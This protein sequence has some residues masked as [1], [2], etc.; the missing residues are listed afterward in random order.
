[1]PFDYQTW[2]CSSRFTHWRLS[3]SFLSP[4]RPSLYDTY[5]KGTHKTNIHTTNHQQIPR[6]RH[7]CVCLCVREKKSVRQSKRKEEGESDLTSCRCSSSS[8]FSPSPHRHHHHRHGGWEEENWTKAN[9]CIH[10]F[11]SFSPCDPYSESRGAGAGNDDDASRAEQTDRHNRTGKSRNLLPLFR[12]LEDGK[13]VR[14][15]MSWTRVCVYNCEAMM[16]SFSLWNIFLFLVPISSSSHN[17]SVGI[18]LPFFPPNTFSF[19][20]IFSSSDE[21]LYHY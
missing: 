2:L 10:M 8:S 17:Q 16:I 13:S 20:Q 21:S 12:I 9:T 19:H 14:E 7:M 11:S 4:F 3:S 6:Q 5:A 1:M 18:M 15:M